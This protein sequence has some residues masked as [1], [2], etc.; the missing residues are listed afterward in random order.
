MKILK[1]AIF[2]ALPA[3]FLLGFMPELSAKCHNKY[4]KKSRT[5]VSFNV[6]VNATPYYR[7]YPAYPAYTAY[8]V[9]PAPV[10]AAPGYYQPAAIATPYPYTPVYPVVV[11]R[12]VVVQQQPAV[13]VGFYL[14][15]SRSYWR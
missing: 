4:Y 8:P 11:E 14:G 1:K 5:S 9:V 2:F 12:P 13:G 10:V 15:S 6:G 3:L 7:A